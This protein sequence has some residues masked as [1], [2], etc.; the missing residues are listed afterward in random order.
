MKLAIR[1]QK[2]ATGVAPVQVPAVAAVVDTLAQQAHVAHVGATPAAQQQP[3]AHR[4][5]AH[6]E[7]VAQGS[8]RAYRRHEPVP[9]LHAVHPAA[10]APRVQ[11]T[12]PRHAA[13][14][15][16]ALTVQAA[17]GG[18]AHTASEAEVHAA[19]TPKAHGEQVAQADAP[20]AGA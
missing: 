18:R 3:P 7:G 13:V 2:V 8:P 15:H 16:W 9:R 14:E 17:P 1:G 19:T 11:H 5:E 6:S 4:W 10:A 12:P 20:L